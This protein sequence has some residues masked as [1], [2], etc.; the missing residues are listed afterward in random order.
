[1]GTALVPLLFSTYSPPETQGT[2]ISLL[3]PRPTGATHYLLGC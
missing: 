2:T 1:M 3:S